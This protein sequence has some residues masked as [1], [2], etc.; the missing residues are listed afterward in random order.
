MPEL[1]SVNKSIIEKYLTNHG[2]FN[3]AGISESK[4]IAVVKKDGNNNIDTKMSVATSIKTYADKYVEEKIRADFIELAMDIH[5][6]HRIE[7]K[8]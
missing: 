6:T 8:E 5:N 1:G 3:V 7:A 4:K 2:A